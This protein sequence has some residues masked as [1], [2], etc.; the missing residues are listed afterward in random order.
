MAKVLIVED[1]ELNRRMY[2]QIFTLKGHDVE[3]ASDGE[4][5]LEKAKST[6]PTLILLDIMMPRLNGLD[7]LREAKKVPGI[8]NIPV[9]VLTNL[10]GATDAE[11]SLHAGA[12][13]YVNKSDYKPKEVV[14]I[15]E[16]I[17]SGYV[18]N[19]V[20]GTQG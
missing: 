1:D 8:A 7:M 2:Q 14:D 9:V 10:V 3:T 20:P 16:G 13:K 19:E 5:G 17:L 12:V 4:E 11:Q 6:N 18:R 15:V